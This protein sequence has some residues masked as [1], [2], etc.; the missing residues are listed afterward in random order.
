MVA[1]LVA[2]RSHLDVARWSGV[3]YVPQPLVIAEGGPADQVTVAVRDINGTPE[4]REIVLRQSTA[5][6]GDSVS[7]WGLDPSGAVVALVAVLGC[8]DGSHTYG[9]DGAVLQGQ[10][11]TARCDDSPA[12]PDEWTADV[13]TWDPEVGSFVYELT[14]AEG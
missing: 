14:E 5:A 9:A 13:Y 12:P 7:L 2:G 8:F 3:D 6:G 11:I 4:S 1:S 10:R